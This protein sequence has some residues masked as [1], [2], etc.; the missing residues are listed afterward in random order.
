MIVCSRCRNKNVDTAKNCRFCG[1]PLVAPVHPEPPQPEAVEPPLERS[2]EEERSQEALLE[3]AKTVVEQ[4]KTP[5]LP[6]PPPKPPEESEWARQDLG[7]VAQIT[8]DSSL[9]TVPP[10][11]VDPGAPNSRLA[12][13]AA[14]VLSVAGLAGGYFAGAHNAAVRQPADGQARD[15]D[16]IKIKQ[17]TVAIAAKDE[18]LQSLQRQVAEL[19]AQVKAQS[20]SSQTQ[21]Q[22]EAAAHAKDL[23]IKALQ[24]RLSAA[25]EESANEA[26]THQASLAQLQAANNAAGEK[27]RQLEAQLATATAELNSARSKQNT[28]VHSTVRSGEITWSGMVD[29]NKTVEIRDGSPRT[30]GTFTGSLPG[31]PVEVRAKD[32]A[33]VTIKVVPAPGHGNNWGHLKFQVHGHGNVTA[34]II[35]TAQ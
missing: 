13:I 21:S 6:E 7:G 18:Q 20:D 4:E 16:Q 1:F 12:W 15:A 14:I 22:I 5:D 25:D 11:P 26:R 24:Q 19:Q 17:D 27:L 28:V 32:P 10:R 23:K 29:G 3:P 30:D 2:Q 33:V 35:W 31:I 9:R 34:T 8:Q